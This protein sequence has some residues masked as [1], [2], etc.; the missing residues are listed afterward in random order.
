MPS[1]SAAERGGGM[2]GYCE[3]CA[4]EQTCTKMIGIWVGF[5]ST[6]FE[7]K[8]EDDDDHEAEESH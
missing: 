7:P 4:K 8:G 6:D 2:T 5:C 3:N 1:T